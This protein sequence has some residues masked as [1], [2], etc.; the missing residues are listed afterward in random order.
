MENN[1]MRVAMAVLVVAAV[2]VT[3]F[4]MILLE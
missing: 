1:L 4:M 3:A 2:Q